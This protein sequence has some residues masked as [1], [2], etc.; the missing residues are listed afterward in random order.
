MFVQCNHLGSFH[1]FI[2]TLLRRN[3]SKNAA[4]PL[5]RGSFRYWKRSSL[6]T[7]FKENARLIV[8]TNMS[9]TFVK[10]EAR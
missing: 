7:N 9:T 4:M 8:S 5:C 10:T 2:I 6:V 1:P 3:G